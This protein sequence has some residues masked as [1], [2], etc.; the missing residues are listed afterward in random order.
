MKAALGAGVGASGLALGTAHLY[1]TTDWLPPVLQRS[2][3]KLSERLEQAHSHSQSLL[4]KGFGR[5]GTGARRSR[6]SRPL[7]RA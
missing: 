2:A 3:P 7:A 1:K 6:S 5:V 4:Q